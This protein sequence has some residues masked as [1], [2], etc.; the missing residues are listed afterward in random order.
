MVGGIPIVND[1]ERPVF[2]KH[3]FLAELKQWL[4]QRHETQAVLMSGSGSTLF[5][6]LHD[7]ADAENLARSAR[8]EIDPHLWHHCGQTEAEC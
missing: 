7:G 2:G 8:H 4:L 6:I 1:L 3:R 5:A